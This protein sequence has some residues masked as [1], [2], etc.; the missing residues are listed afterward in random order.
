MSKLILLFISFFFSLVL[1]FSDFGQELLALEETIG[2][3]STGLSEDMIIKCLSGKM[4]TSGDQYCVEGSC[5]ICLVRTLR[6][7]TLSPTNRV[8]CII[9]IQRKIGV[10]LMEC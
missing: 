1:K 4:Y 10:Y 2:N 9:L 6:I 8:F 3:V 7:C 5:A